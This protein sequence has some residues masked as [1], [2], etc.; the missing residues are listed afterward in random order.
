MIGKS[1]LCSCVV[2]FIR[3]YIATGMKLGEEMPRAMNAVRT[4]SR[5]QSVHVLFRVIG[6]FRSSDVL[7]VLS[8][9]T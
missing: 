9:A 6:N 5:I 2:P 4:E 1:L 3:S 7:E 8:Y